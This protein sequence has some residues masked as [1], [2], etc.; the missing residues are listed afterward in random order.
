MQ[1]TFHLHMIENVKAEF[2]NVQDTCM[3]ITYN[4]NCFDFV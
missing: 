2:I 3:K 1:P 4:K